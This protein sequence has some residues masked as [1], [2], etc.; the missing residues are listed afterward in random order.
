MAGMEGL[1]RIFDVVP[2]AAGLVL[3]MRGAS[4]VTYVCTGADTFT[5][6]VGTSHAAAATSPGNIFTHYYQRADTVGA[7]AWTK[8]TQAASNAIVQAGAYTTVFT[9]FTSQFSDPNDYVKCLQSSAGLV[10]AIFHD[11]VVQR[12]PAN[13]EVL[14]A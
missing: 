13:L 6:T 4:A 12:A 8:V 9:V 2:I 3:K 7:V 5:V 14:N 11:L 1:G 10:T